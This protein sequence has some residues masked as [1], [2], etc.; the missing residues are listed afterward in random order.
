MKKLIKRILRES[1]GLNE[2]GSKRSKDTDVIYNDGNVV[3]LVPRTY[4]SCLSY[5][6]NTQYCTKNRYMYDTHNKRGDDMFRILFKDGNKIR[7]TWDYDGSF[8]WGLGS[9][10]NYVVFSEKYNFNSENPFDFS[11]IE[12]QKKDA[13]WWGDDYDLLLKYMNILPKNSIEK[14]TE[15]HEN[16]KMI[17]KVVSESS[18]FDWI[19]EAGYTE[20]EEFII[21]LIDSCDVVDKK[22]GEAYVLNGDV[23]FYKD[24]RDMDFYYHDDLVGKPL[25]NN[26]NIE[27]HEATILI[28]DILERH[29]N[30]S[31]DVGT[32]LNMSY[33]M[34]DI[35]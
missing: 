35:T 22:Y 26:F 31:Y 17:G 3:V 2:I 6:Q 15:Y 7:L 28:S 29:Y 1:I 12:E 18:D 4:E 10:K 8:S 9:G 16:K 13:S 5:S 25:K 24:F 32:A 11:L 27:Q 14:I 34:T 20:E 21:N 19:E 23:Y 33:F 30:I